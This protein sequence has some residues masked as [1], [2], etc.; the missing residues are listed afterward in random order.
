MY[1]PKSRIL[2]NQY[3]SDNTLVYKKDKKPYKG[4]YY[5]TF[6]GKY[7][8]G[9]TQNDPPNEELLKVEDI[10]ST[11]IVETPQNSIAYSDAPT[12]FDDINTP[13]YSENM[14]VTY[15][16]LQKVDLTKSTEINIPTQFYPE[17]GAEEYNV[18]SFTRYFC[19]K[20]NQPIWLEIDS[21]TF[22]KMKDRSGE[23]LW[24]PYKLVTLQ[25]AL[26]GDEKYVATTNRNIIA[27]AEKRNKVQG[28]N[29]FL[30]GNWL[31]FY[32]EKDQR[33]IDKTLDK[34]KIRKIR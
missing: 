14:V 6:N 5:K 13:G 30:R 25:W 12:I 26:I 16:N 19:V 23:W 3:T 7:F 8:T 24:Q 17:P 28:L 9:K 27:L 20:I 34:R 32:K 31:K 33:G 10:N 1:I 29:A 11:P 2:T 4:F 18:G 15:A 22:D 21:D